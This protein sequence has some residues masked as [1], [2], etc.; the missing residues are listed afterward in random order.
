M[1]SFFKSLICVMIKTFKIKKKNFVFKKL[2]EIFFQIYTKKI[3]KKQLKI[4]KKR[5]N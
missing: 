5:K 3:Y 2:F 4:L 1:I